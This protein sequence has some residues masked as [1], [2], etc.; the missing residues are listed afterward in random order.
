MS[1]LE[2]RVKVLE[3]LL[4]KIQKGEDAIFVQNARRRVLGGADVTDLPPL[5]LSDLTDVG[6]DTNSPSTNQVLK[7]DGTDWSP[8]TDN[9]A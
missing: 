5:R 7:Y 8:G 3:E 9:T 4:L 6:S 1:P 2:K